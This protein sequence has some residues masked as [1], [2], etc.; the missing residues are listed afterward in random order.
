VTPSAA[1]SIERQPPTQT[2]KRWWT[3]HPIDAGHTVNS[4]YPRE[5]E[6]FL[7]AHPDILD[8]QVIG[9]P[10]PKY[11]EELMVWIRM[12][13]G[14]TPLDSAALREFSAGRLAHF[15]IPRYVHVVEEFPMTVT[16]K[17]RKAEMR[18][19]PKAMLATPEQP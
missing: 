7:Y 10:D 15:K 4:I 12:R 13:D 17:V 19:L 1:T 9:V 3:V 18:E 14:A 8:A 16:G 11:G 6:E 2:E 5:I